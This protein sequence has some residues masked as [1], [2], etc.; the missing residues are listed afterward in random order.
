MRAIFL[1]HQQAI[2]AA[3]EHLT[4]FYRVYVT[5][6][7]IFERTQ[8]VAFLKWAMNTIM[9]IGDV[10]QGRPPCLS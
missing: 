6:L 4:F 2:A 1:L 7:R 8:G 9:W 5:S 3:D 10:E